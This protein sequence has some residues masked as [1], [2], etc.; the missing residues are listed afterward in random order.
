MATHG[1]GGDRARLT[2]ARGGK[3]QFKWDNVKTDEH[4]ELFLGMFASA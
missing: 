3:D 1:T 4:R 2:G